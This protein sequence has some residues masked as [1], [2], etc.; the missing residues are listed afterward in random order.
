MIAALF[1]RRNSHYKVIP[2]VDAYDE[3]RNALTWRGG[4]PGVFHPPCRSWGKLAHFSK[5][6]PGERELALWSMGMVRQWGGVVEHPLHSRLWRESGCA[7]FGVRDDHGGILLP[8]YQSWWG[9]RAPKATGLYIVGPLP[10]LPDYQ[11][12]LM[13]QSVESM[14]QAS[15]EMTPPALASWLVATAAACGG[16]Q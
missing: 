15:R 14:S 6:Q 13:V 3:N 5:H 16:V 8:V 1:V 9:H 2:G 12:P 10:D 7:S 11:P 4:C